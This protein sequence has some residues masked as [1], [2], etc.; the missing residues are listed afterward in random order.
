MVDTG[1]RTPGDGLSVG[2]ATYPPGPPDRWPAWVPPLPARP[3]SVGA[4]GPTGG[5]GGP[6]DRRRAGLV[7]AAAAVVLLVVV[8]AVALATRG[9]GD[10]TA[11]DTTT[12]TS[13]STTSAV[14]TL[15]SQPSI[16]GLDPTDPGLDPSDDAQPLADVLPGLIDFVE[17]ARGHAFRTDPVVEPLPEDEFLDRF[18][19][20]SAGDEDQLREAGVAQRALGILDPDSDPVAI[21]DDLGEQ[22]VLG[23]YD[24]ESEELVVRGDE[25][26]PY[27]ETIIVHELT[28]ALDDQYVDLEQADGLA[29]RP[30]ES[31]FGFLALTEGTARHVQVAYE[32]QLSPDEVLSAQIESLTSQLGGAGSTS[33]PLPLPF[34]V[35]TQLPYGN[36]AEL[37][38]ALVDGGGTAAIDAAYE[39]PPTTSEQVLDPAAY[40]A[41]EPATA[42]SAPSADGPV[43]DEGAFGAVDLRILQVVAD[44]TS[45]TDLLEQ[46]GAV[47]PTI[48]VDPLDGFGGGQYVSWEQ[49]GQA[50]IRFT[51]VGDSAVGAGQVVDIV[52]AWAGAVG[53]ATVVPAGGG[54]GGVTATR[55]A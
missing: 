49:G 12:S 6:P 15:P 29:D 33:D 5:P 1:P 41:S 30:D 8:G 14:P 31:G 7:A 51:V 23:F 42:V 2:G 20:A 48:A 28:H 46:T 11:A 9:G 38:D 34:S 18:R 26:T 35:A 3:G 24:P 19:S 13:E 50:C 25:I 32:D 40:E 45:A 54:A 27:V 16:P 43:A 52:Q 17:Q 53:G 4:G 22:G 21:Q 47:S 10:D 37:V 44:P 55:C 39:A 36:G